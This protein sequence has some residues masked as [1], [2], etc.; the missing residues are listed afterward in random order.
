[1]AGFKLSSDGDIEVDSNGKMLLLSTYQELVQQRLNIKLR[2]YKG[3]W[4]LDTT[5]GIPYRD[6]GDGKAIIGKGFTKADIDALY[7]AA[8]REDSDVQSI[9]YFNS[10]YN[11]TFRNYNVVFEVKVLDKLLNSNSVGL[12]AWEEVTYN[13][14]PALLTS[15]CNIDFSDWVTELHPVVHE[16]LPDALQPPYEW[17]E[18]SYFYVYN[19]YVDSGYVEA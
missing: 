12:Q 8:I 11:S 2:T 4:W 9:E 19:G 6:T 13:Y 14:N 5:F 16:D 17:S 15:S 1:M 7:I 18:G 10:E 3:E